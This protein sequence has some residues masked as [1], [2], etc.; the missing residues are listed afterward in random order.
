MSLVRVMR[1][2]EGS[3]HF[4]DEIV[5]L[6]LLCTCTDRLNLLV[7]LNLATRCCERVKDGT[8]YI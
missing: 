2:E 7:H 3:F 1:D 8:I 4:A 5:R 6:L